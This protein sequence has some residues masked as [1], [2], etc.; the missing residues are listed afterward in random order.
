MW[1]KCERSCRLL[2]TIVITGR[3]FV[4]NP[5]MDITLTHLIEEESGLGNP[6]RMS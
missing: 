4:A 1:P 2:T 3:E 6:S 5:N